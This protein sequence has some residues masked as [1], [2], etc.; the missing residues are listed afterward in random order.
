MNKEIYLITNRKLCSD[1]KFIEVIKEA[2]FNGVSKIILREKD[3]SFFELETLYNKLIEVINKESSVIINSNVDLAIKY[4]A[5]GI[6]LPYKI[7]IEYGGKKGIEKNRH[8]YGKVGV[9][10]HSVEEALECSR[11]KADYIIASHIFE[12][13]CKE[14]LKPKGIGFIEKISEKVSIPVIALG[15]IKSNNYKE[16]LQGGADGIAIMSEIMTS[17]N[18]KETLERFNLL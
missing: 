7:F 9:S 5:F 18:V 1:E 15:G 4:N 14:G 8:Y 13:K 6:Q 11:L 3:L 16:V 2:S 12:T 10:T 17:N